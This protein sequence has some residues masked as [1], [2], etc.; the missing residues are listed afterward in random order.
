M[1]KYA[2]TTP[3]ARELVAELEFVWDQ[4]KSNS[5]SSSS[6]SPNQHPALPS[7]LHHSRS[8]TSIQ[9]GTGIGG[10]RDGD[11]DGGLR[12]LRP[13]SDGDEDEGDEDEDQDDFAEARDGLLP[14]DFDPAA[15]PGGDASTRLYDLRNRKWRKRMEQAI[16]RLTT[17]VA[18]LREQLEAKRFLQRQQRENIWA[19]LRWFVWVAV[20]HLV[21]DAVV[22]GVVMLWARRKGVEGGVGGLL[23]GV[24]EGLVER[25]KRVRVPGRL[26]LGARGRD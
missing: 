13:V 25:I 2:S 18:A 22:W 5:I 1:H 3:E 10:A 24:V 23:E 14:Y 6:S 11:S 9:P 20:R 17:E 26:R 19:W 21:V 12:A 7:P 4:I 15:Q 16:V 8:Y